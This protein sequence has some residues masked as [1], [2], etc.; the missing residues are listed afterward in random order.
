MGAYTT[1][2]LT[3][4]LT[5]LLLGL[6]GGL[7]Q[8]VWSHTIGMHCDATLLGDIVMHFQCPA[9]TELFLKYPP[10]AAPPLEAATLAAGIAGF[11]AGAGAMWRPPWAALL[12]AAL[13]AVNLAFVS[14]ALTAGE[15][16]GRAIGLSA[17]AVVVPLVAAG[18]TWR[19]GEYRR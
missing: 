16:D 12:F 5:A 2:Q 17:L 7:C 11:A 15:Q 8:L 9:W 3:S 13:A 18:I 19:W 4:R 1:S 6:F 10:S 14:G